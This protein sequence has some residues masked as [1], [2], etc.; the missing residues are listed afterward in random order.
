MATS[1]PH[2]LGISQRFGLY[3][4]ILIARG[5][6]RV[7]WNDTLGFQIA[8]K[9]ST[10]PVVD[11]SD[12][13]DIAQAVED[14]LHE[15]LQSGVYRGISYRVISQPASY[16]RGRHDSGGFHAVVNG[17]DLNQH[18]E[19]AANAVIAVIDWI[20]KRLDAKAH[21]CQ[22]AQVLDYFDL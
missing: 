19:T 8:P 22:P 18:F 15:A 14:F 11:A 7:Q 3:N 20:D 9:G 10:W 6:T 17:D 21:L 4:L 16:G 5:G 12:H 1:S 13:P 2:S